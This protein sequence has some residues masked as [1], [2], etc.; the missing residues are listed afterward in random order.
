MKLVPNSTLS[1]E[2]KITDKNPR[3]QSILALA[4][5]PIWKKQY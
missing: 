1:S 3:Q 2:P 4:M 5:H